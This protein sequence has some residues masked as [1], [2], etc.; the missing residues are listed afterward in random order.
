MDEKIIARIFISQ[1]EINEAWETIQKL[2]QTNDFII[3]RAII[4]ASI[5]MYSR[6][7]QKNK[8]SKG[9]IASKLNFNDLNLSEDTKEIHEKILFYRDK[10][11]AHSDGDFHEIKIVDPGAEM[12]I[13]NNIP[14]ANLF[15]LGKKLQSHFEI[16][17]DKLY[18][19]NSGG[20]SDE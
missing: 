16:V 4:C 7:F 13:M 10:M 5:V 2:F 3:N 12:F 8:T 20:G 18:Q 15:E 19:L 11:V 1:N 14:Y 6:A 17:L 9:A